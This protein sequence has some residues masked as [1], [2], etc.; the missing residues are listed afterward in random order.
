[1]KKMKK[2]MND[3]I[4]FNSYNE[5]FILSNMYPVTIEYKGMNF[6][7]V[8]NLYHYLLYY[9][10][11]DIQSKIL[12]K[13]KGV[14][15]N[16]QAKKISEEN[17]ELVKN[18]TDSQKVNLLKK[19]M[20]LKYEQS[21]HCREYLLNTGDKPLIEFAYWGDAFCGCVLKNGEYI[22]DNHTGL[23]LQQIRDELRGN[24][25]N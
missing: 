9:Q 1:M 25:T 4:A 17:R 21:Q 3:S 22:G 12:K 10:H 23:I 11:P 20:R 8:D 15:A 7:G 24:I 19:C 14:C 13:S 6:F 18:I 5:H 2:M 16:Y